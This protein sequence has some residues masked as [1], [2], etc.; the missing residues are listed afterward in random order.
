MSDQPTYTHY[1]R[2]G[3]GP[4]EDWVSSL[5]V[6]SYSSECHWKCLDCGTCYPPNTV[7]YKHQQNYRCRECHDINFPGVAQ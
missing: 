3:V 7:V 2:D 4:G 1:E 5:P 6:Y